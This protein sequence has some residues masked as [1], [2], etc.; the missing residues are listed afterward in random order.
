MIRRSPLLRALGAA[1]ALWASV[2]QMEPA[3][4]HVCAKH[5]ATAPA[6]GT[7]A[8]M[9]HSAGHHHAAPSTSTQSN[10][11]SSKCCTCP[12]GCAVTAA[13][14]LPAGHELV[15]P[16]TR[17]FVA[18]TPEPRDEVRPSSAVRLLPFANGPP[19]LV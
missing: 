9:I 5:S 13:T 10:D 18:R 4:L 6:A 19:S 17:A 14:S 7:M 3:S 2:V 16:A 8:G 11:E 12:G 1:M 15:I